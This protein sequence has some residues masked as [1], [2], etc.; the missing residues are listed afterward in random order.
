[1]AHWID[2][3]SEVPEKAK[4]YFHRYFD[5]RSAWE[6]CDNGIY[7]IYLA[8]QYGAAWEIAGVASLGVQQLRNALDA[9]GRSVQVKNPDDPLVRAYRDVIS[10]VEI[11]TGK[12]EGHVTMRPPGPASTSYDGYRADALKVIADAIR[13]RMSPPDP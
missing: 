6:R 8:R 4:S 7:L 1:M 9:H 12:A 11:A 3:A 13:A 10:D 2:G 5:L